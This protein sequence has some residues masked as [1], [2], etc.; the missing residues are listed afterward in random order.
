MITID[1]HA[2]IESALKQ[3]GLWERG[4]TL[5][6]VQRAGDGNMNSVLRVTTSHRRVILK[7]SRP[8]VEKYP[9]IAAPADRI[10]AEIDFYRRVAPHDELARSMPKLLAAS[11]ELHLMAMED[12]GQASDYCDLYQSRDV[13][14]M[15]LPEATQWLS[16]L[17]RIPLDPNEAG[18]VGCHE[19]RELN[20]QHMFVIPLQ[21]PSAIP[22][23]DVCAGLED[24]A[25][26]VRSNQRIHQIASSLGERYLGTGPCLLHGDFYPGSWLS[27]GDGMRVIDPEFC[28]AGPAEFDLGVLAGHRVLVGGGED[29]VDVV[30]RHYSESG[31]G[32]IDDGLVSQFAAMEVIRRLIGVAQLPLSATL[33]QRE[34]MIQV[35][36]AL[37]ES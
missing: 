24:L 18:R 22:L 31:G 13:A 3:I 1:D 19:L 30:L 16:Q 27:T 21:T 2:A 7:Q 33:K 37:I 35:A 36:T 23:D 34:N 28:F 25:A 11:D 5:E 17:H 12:L 29:S 20:H 15:P 10:F 9:Q 8:W 32:Q 6:D 4:E 26:D 14:S